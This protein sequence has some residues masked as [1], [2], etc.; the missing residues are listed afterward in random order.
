MKYRMKL[1]RRLLCD[2]RASAA[3]AKIPVKTARSWR[4][5]G[6]NLGSSAVFARH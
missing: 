4:R 3:D 5:P 6:R 1:L 2:Q